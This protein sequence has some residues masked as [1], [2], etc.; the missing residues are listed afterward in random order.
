MNIFSSLFA[1]LSAVIIVA[2]IGVQNR[3]KQNAI[4][5]SAQSEPCLTK[6]PCCYVKVNCSALTFRVLVLLKVTLA[7][8]CN[9]TIF[10]FYFVLT[11]MNIYQ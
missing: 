1:V 5:T 3:N 6:H 9:E 4:K 2:V 10:I 7:V 11:F 8:L